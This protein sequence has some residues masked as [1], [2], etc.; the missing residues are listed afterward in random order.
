MNMRSYLRDFR[1]VH[2]GLLSS[3][4]EFTVAFSQT[5]VDPMYTFVN[6]K[7]PFSLVQRQVEVWMQRRLN[8]FSFQDL[9]IAE[10]LIDLWKSFQLLYATI[11]ESMKKAILEAEK[12]EDIKEQ[13]I[14]MEQN[15]KKIFTTI[16]PLLVK[17][18][19]IFASLK[20][21]LSAND[22]RQELQRFASSFTNPA[23][24]ST[25]PD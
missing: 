21:S 20:E 23:T 7:M 18:H 25:C 13:E 3:Y 5:T 16:A 8:C 10:K 4:L 17:C 19:C 9:K 22:P 6:E 11:Y 12:L 24:S 2:D 1:Q 14:S 15:I